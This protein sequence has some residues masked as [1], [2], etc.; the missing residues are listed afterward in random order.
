[1][2]KALRATLEAIQHAAES[3]DSLSRS[4]HQLASAP[5]DH[6]ALDDRLG[7]LESTLELRLAEGDALLIKAGSL[8]AAARAAEERERKLAASHSSDEERDPD[9]FTEEEIN[10]AYAD[11]G[12][13]LEHGASGEGEEV[14][15]VSPVLDEG[16]KGKSAALALKWGAA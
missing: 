14:Q 12:I 10:Q 9:E 4:L 13:Q 7:V 6:D 1:M 15:A 11:A 3:L 5:S 2:F 8:K 16:R